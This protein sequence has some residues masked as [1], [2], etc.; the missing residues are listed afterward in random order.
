MTSLLIGVIEYFHCEKVHELTRG[1]MK[2]IKE[3]RNNPSSK[4]ELDKTIS[5]IGGIA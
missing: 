2:V 5:I 4:Y 1:T 3:Q